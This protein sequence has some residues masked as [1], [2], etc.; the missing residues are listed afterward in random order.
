MTT[1]SR[2]IAL[3]LWGEVDTDKPA[4]DQICEYA[5]LVAKVVTDKHERVIRQLITSLEE[6]EAVLIAHGKEEE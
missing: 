1:I 4:A 6:L 2:P 3:M 5:Q